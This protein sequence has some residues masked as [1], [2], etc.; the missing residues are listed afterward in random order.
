LHVASVVQPYSH[1]QDQVVGAP[2]ATA[3]VPVAVPVI[4]PETTLLLQ[5]Q[6]T[7]HCGF[8]LLQL[9]SVV[10][11]NIPTQ[12]QVVGA[13][14]ATAI[15]PV[16]IP[17]IQLDTVLLSQ[18]QFIGGSINHISTPS[19]HLMTSVLPINLSS[20][21]D[22]SIPAYQAVTLIVLICDAIRDHPLMARIEISHVGNIVISAV[23][24]PV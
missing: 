11:P 9:V 5:D 18:V 19:L 1:A 16:A 3:I 6:F 7:G 22:R 20:K 8:E 17:V 15:V 4:Q 24:T 21:T 2:H 23:V 12:D 13:P 10:Q 14:H